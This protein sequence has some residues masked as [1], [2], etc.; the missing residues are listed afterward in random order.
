MRARAARLRGFITRRLERIS[1]SQRTILTF[2]VV[3]IISIGLLAAFTSMRTASVLSEEV[4]STTSQMVGSTAQSIGRRFEEAVRVGNL[5]LQQSTVINAMER[6][7]YGHN[8]PLA[9]QLADARTMEDFAY[10]LQF[11]HNL[12][13]VRLLFLGDSIYVNENINFF[14]LGQAEADQ[15]SQSR[16]AGNYVEIT[17]CVFPYVFQKAQRVFTVKSMLETPYDFYEIM[18]AAAVDINA[19]EVFSLLR[20]MVTSDHE[21]VVL[22]DQD[23]NTIYS[24]GDETLASMVPG[25][26]PDTWQVTDDNTALHYTTMI[27]G[28]GWSLSF[29]INRAQL[30]SS[31]S[32][33]QRDLLYAMLVILA[34]AYMLTLVSSRITVRRIRSLANAMERV[35]DGD[36]D[37]RV[38]EGGSNEVSVLEHSFNYL[39]DVLHEMLENKTQ[40]RLALQNARIRLLQSQIQP[41][42][43]YNTLDLISWRLLLHDDHE[44]SRL[45]QALA[46]FY[47]IGLSRGRD[48]ITLHDELQHVQLY[49]EIQNFRLDNRV[50]LSIQVDGA[51]LVQLLPGNLLQPLVENAIQHGILESETSEGIVSITARSLGD[52]FVIDIEDDGIG[53]DAARMDDLVTRQEGHH[54]G[55]WNIQQRIQLLYGAAFGLAY[56]AS[57]LGGVKATITMP[58]N[59]R[60]EHLMQRDG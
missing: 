36:L 54:F 35:R 43:L 41:H 46:Q 44:G 42:F 7:A 51:M 31:V 26:Q 6:M 55:V 48:L 33:L 47:K 30:F 59:T 37:F 56:G 21:A 60:S 57:A 16:R 17:E 2:F 12:V 14:P 58:R 49:V 28:F 13:R 52:S 19:E 32:L 8:Y 10:R 25:T 1:I 15:L 5:V 9:D 40:D 27:N 45:V 4:M 50:R 3:I 34:G 24:V 22:L 23:G 11:S 38:P 18:G 39:L 20:K 29:R 53:V